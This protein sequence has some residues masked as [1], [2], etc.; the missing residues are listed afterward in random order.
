MTLALCQFTPPPTEKQVSFF[1]R[2]RNKMP[3]STISTFAVATLADTEI[4]G[5]LF[6]WLKALAEQKKPMHVVCGTNIDFIMPVFCNGTEFNRWWNIE[7]NACDGKW[8][9]MRSSSESKLQVGDCIHV[10]ESVELPECTP[11][12][13]RRGVSHCVFEPARRLLQAKKD[14]AKSKSTMYRYN[15]KIN[16]LKDLERKYKDGVP[17]DIFNEIADLTQLKFHIEMVLSN[18]DP[19]IDAAPSKKAL[20][21]VRLVN[22][23]FGHVDE[24]VSGDDQHAEVVSSDKLEELRLRLVEEGRWFLWRIS[25]GETYE[26]RTLDGVYTDR[27]ASEYVTMKMEF[28]KE[29]HLLDMKLDALTDT[30]T[31][32]FLRNGTHWNGSIAFGKPAIGER[33]M[34]ID[35]NASYANFHLAPFYKGF[36]SKLTDARRTDKIQGPGFYRVTDIDWAGADERFATYCRML[37]GKKGNMYLDWNIYPVPDLDLIDHYGVSYKIVEGVWAGGVQPTIDFRF[38]GTYEAQDG[39]YTKPMRPGD[40]E[41]R[42]TGTAYY[43]MWVGS[44]FSDKRSKE[45]WMHGSDEFF[46][47]VKDKHTNATV[48][49]FENGEGQVKFPKQRMWV[50][51]TIPGYINAHERAMIITELMKIPP[52]TLFHLQKDAIFCKA[53]DIALSDYF[54]VEEKDLPRQDFKYPCY[55]SHVQQLYPMT[56]DAYL[57]LPNV[58]RDNVPCEAH[59]GVG[60]S[61]KTENLLKDAGFVRMFYCGIGYKLTRAKETEYPDCDFKTQVMANVLSPDPTK[62]RAFQQFFNVLCFDEISM[63][64]LEQVHLAR[65]YYP[66]HK[67]PFAGDPGF[68]LPCITKLTLIP[69]NEN[70]TDRHP[71]DMPYSCLRE[72]VTKMD[73]ANIL[74]PL[75]WDGTHPLIVKVPYNVY[76]ALTKLR[77]TDDFGCS[78]DKKKESQWKALQKFLH[79]PRR[80]VKDEVHV[81]EQYRWSKTDGFRGRLFSGG[82][83]GLNRHL[84]ANILST[85]D[86]LDQC[87]SAQTIIAYVCRLCGVPCPVVDEYVRDREG[88]L[89]RIMQEEGWDRATAKDEAIKVFMRDTMQSRTPTLR[90]LDEEAKR[91]QRQLSQVP[92]LRWVLDAAK[93]SKDRNQLGSFLSR[94]YQVI[95]NKLTL[96]VAFEIGVSPQCLIFDGLAID[97][98][99]NHATVLKAAEE[100]CERL[101][102]GI[103]MKWA[104]KA[105]DYTKLDLRDTPF[106]SL[107]HRG[108]PTTVANISE[109]MPVVTYTKSW[110]QHNC[111]ALTKILTDL[112]ALI[113]AKTAPQEIEKH[114]LAV[115]ADRHITMA[116]AVD[117]YELRDT[118]L[119][120]H[121]A[122]PFNYVK[123]YT[124]A[125][126]PESG[127]NKYIVTA[128]SRAYSNGE[129]LVRDVEP[130]CKC[131]VRHAFTIHS[132]QGETVKDP[133]HL[134]I[135]AR[136]LWDATHWYTA[137]SR[138]QYLRQ[139]YIVM[140]ESLAVN[141]ALETAKIYKIEDR[142][143]GNVY[144]GSTTK[145]LETRLVG[146]QREK[147]VH[148]CT[149]KE[150]IEHGDAEMTL[151]EEYPCDSYHTL[152]ARET[153]HMNQHPTAVNKIR[154]YNEAFVPT[155]QLPRPKR[156]KVESEFSEASRPA[157]PLPGFK[158]QQRLSFRKE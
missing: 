105:Y 129:I 80:Q 72:I 118:V 32:A 58:E 18:G 120:S 88:V 133:D 12:K 13:F 151:L 144:I 156:P 123:E 147:Q 77:E 97:K 143:T 43:K 49:A 125:L 26:I 104:F 137:L 110:R 1:I 107:A 130:D 57:T 19:F 66:F 114:V 94:T 64:T 82:S 124:E 90:R 103:G 4:F 153:F 93:A 98:G 53:Q 78:D 122:E 68:Q 27:G 37:G 109:M 135:D 155:V 100:V 142:T 47:Q 73:T 92:A 106:A 34:H 131:E 17:D 8:H 22:T 145:P 91:I 158:R 81:L 69:Y 46:A 102:P 14:A 3:Q 24:V 85:T 44:C 5:T 48:V 60:G 21:T 141:P 42:P 63:W 121:V 65:A 29:T 30:T 67:L 74:D 101:C 87:A 59:L 127:P 126:T 62:R 9:F 138:A 39:F 38:P 40:E 86:D 10:Y 157:V 76:L 111:P 41:G 56:P 70:Y 2:D 152:R 7:M 28:E 15:A 71:F 6:S 132:I 50:L 140:H 150:L 51:P 136:K 16:L 108:T 128:N 52:D 11:Q 84:R 112:R 83:A 134:F 146:H 95:E 116:E 20:G 149:S 119:V 25:R 23:S 61:G 113:E 117:M 96:A 35:V 45:Y 89:A 79:C 33:H 31:V 54:K 154:A 115:L 75:Q 36:P 99:S 55:T 148:F 139:I